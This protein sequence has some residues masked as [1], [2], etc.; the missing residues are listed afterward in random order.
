MLPQV[1]V[2]ITVAK[3]NLGHGVGKSNGSARQV[4]SA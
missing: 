3:T 1:S 2:D 4:D